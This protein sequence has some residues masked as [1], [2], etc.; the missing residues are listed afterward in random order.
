MHPCALTC[1]QGVYPYTQQNNHPL[2]LPWLLLY[3]FIVTDLTLLK[4]NVLKCNN[5]VVVLVVTFLLCSLLQLIHSIDEYM[6]PQ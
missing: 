6:V 5:L 3:N 4:P 2:L 1:G